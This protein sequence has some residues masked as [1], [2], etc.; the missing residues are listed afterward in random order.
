[1]DKV[2][3]QNC[4]CHIDS[5]CIS[6]DDVVCNGSSNSTAHELCGQAHSEVY[7]FGS[8]SH[9]TSRLQE[10]HTYHKDLEFACQHWRP[11]DLELSPFKN[12]LFHVEQLLSTDAPLTQ[13]CALH[14]FTWVGTAYRNLNSLKFFKLWRV[15]FILLFR[16]LALPQKIPFNSFF[17]LGVIFHL[18]FFL[19]LNR[20][21]HHLDLRTQT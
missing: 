10:I 6:G 19:D 18:R 4:L 9:F 13:L 17:V 11:F 7:H 3:Q 16:A 14:Y 2:Q 12:S 15:Q 5:F 20:R 21:E 8:G 1:M